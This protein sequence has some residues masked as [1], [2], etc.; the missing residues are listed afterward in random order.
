MASELRALMDSN[1]VR[2]LDLVQDN[3]G[4]R[5]DDRQDRRRAP[6]LFR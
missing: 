3:R 5:R 4:D 2:V 6:G 1:T